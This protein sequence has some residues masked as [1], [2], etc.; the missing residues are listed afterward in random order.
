MFKK[1]LVGVVA[2]SLLATSAYATVTISGVKHT[3]WG[4]KRVVIGTATITGAPS[5]ANGYALTPAAIGLEKIESMLLTPY[6]GSGVDYSWKYTSGYIV[7][8][9]KGWLDFEQVVSATAQDSFKCAAV[10]TMATDADTTLLWVNP[11]LGPLSRFVSMGCTGT[12]AA[13]YDDPIYT[14]ADSTLYAQMGDT[15]AGQMILRARTERADTVFFDYNASAGDRLAYSGTNLGNM[16]DLYVPWYDGKMIKVRYRTGAQMYAAGIGAAIGYMMYCKNGEV[17]NK[18]V[19]KKT[20]GASLP[21][22]GICTNGF[23][24]AQPNLPT[25]SITAVVY[26]VA[27]GN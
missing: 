26:F 11:V 13:T 16:G 4:N 3:T 12:T 7:P 5:N 10:V 20:T 8:F 22:S 25:N 2:L 19:W 17:D 18:F 21:A 23:Y 27:I 24:A 9:R 6:S 1:I 14:N 15:I